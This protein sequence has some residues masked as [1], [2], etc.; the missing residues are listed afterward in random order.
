M[1]GQRRVGQPAY[2]LETGPVRGDHLLARRCHRAHEHPA[3][4]EVARER[5][6]EGRPADVVLRVSR[7]KREKLRDREI[8]EP[9]HAASA[10]SGI[11]TRRLADA[12]PE[13]KQRVSLRAEPD[14]EFFDVRTQQGQGRKAGVGPRKDLGQHRDLPSMGA[15]SGAIATLHA[16]LC[17]VGWL[18]NRATLRIPPAHCT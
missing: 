15:P 17:G 8:F 13:G 1:V 18:R 4:V 7:G 11:Q 6:D 14:G 3:H 16:E 2:P 10:Q 12:Q 9:T 5:A